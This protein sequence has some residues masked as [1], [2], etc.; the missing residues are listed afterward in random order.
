M[1]DPEIEI[2]RLE[3]KQSELANKAAALQKKMGMPSYE[4]KTPEHVK[5]AD[6]AALEKNAVEQAAASAALEGFR[7]MLN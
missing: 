7:A 2:K 4:E 6:M 3:K 1:L 5:E